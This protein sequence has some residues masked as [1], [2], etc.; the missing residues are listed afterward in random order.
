MF[1]SSCLYSRISFCSSWTLCSPWFFAIFSNL[2]SCLT[3]FSQICKGNF[4]INLVTKGQEI[5]K[6]NYDVLNSSKKRSKHTQ[7]SIL[8]EF[9]SFFG[10]IKDI[11][12]CFRDLLTFNKCQIDS[13]DFNNFCGLLRKHEL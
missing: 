1:L 8:V 7:D 10:R 6:A 11:I 5:S 2:F 4:I 13:E 12:I 3:N 9:C